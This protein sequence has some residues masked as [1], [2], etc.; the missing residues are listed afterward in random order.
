VRV[1]NDQ[2]GPSAPLDAMP[3][4][5]MDQTYP[6]PA[7]SRVEFPESFNSGL[8]ERDLGERDLGERRP[9]LLQARAQ[10][11]GPPSKQYGHIPGLM[12][13]TTED[14]R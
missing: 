7:Q 3:P 10:P 5:F 8:G 6:V 1:L 13:L 14:M 2:E 11:V 4:V 12:D 9:Q